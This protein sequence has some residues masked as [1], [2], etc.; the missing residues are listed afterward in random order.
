MLPTTASDLL[1]LDRRDAERLAAQGDVAEGWERLHAGVRRAQDRR[2]AGE[3]WREAF[4]RRYK[5][6]L[7]EYAVRHDLALPAPDPEANE[8]FVEP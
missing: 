7:V 1:S 6:A 8:P 3:T 5:E 4:I 2:F